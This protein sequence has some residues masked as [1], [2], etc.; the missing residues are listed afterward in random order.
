[1]AW[2]G[3]R[4]GRAAGGGALNGHFAPKAKQAWVIGNTIS[5]GFVKGLLVVAR[6]ATPG[7]G[8]PDCWALLQIGTGRWYQFQPHLGLTRCEDERDARRAA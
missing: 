6:I 3:Y 8:R 2:N 4:A 1:M 7:D 5:V